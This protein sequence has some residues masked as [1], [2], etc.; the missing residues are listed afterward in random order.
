MGR[1]LQKRYRLFNGIDEQIAPPAPETYRRMGTTRARG[2]GHTPAVT[3]SEQGA[4]RYSWRGSLVRQTSHVHAPDSPALVLQSEHRRLKTPAHRNGI[5]TPYFME[6]LTAWAAVS[7][8]MRRITDSI[9]YPIRNA[10]KNRTYSYKEK[11]RDLRGT[12]G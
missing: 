1:L 4:N 12:R 11:P 8:K 7:V 3:T 10:G 5:H 9:R 2:A 6:S